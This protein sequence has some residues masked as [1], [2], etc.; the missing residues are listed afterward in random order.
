[1]RE[2][3]YTI[4][5]MKDVLLDMFKF[6]KQFLA[7]HNLH[8]VACGG[9]VLGAVRHKGF[10]PWDDDID[11]YMPRADY[12]RLLTMDDELRPLGY[13]ILSHEKT[14]GYYT[15]FAKLSKMQSTIWELEHLPCIMGVYID[16]FPLDEFDDSDEAITALQYKTHYYYDKYINAVSSY[17]PSY[18][19]QRLAQFDFHKAGV[20]LLHL[21][22]RRH[23]E[24]YL[25]AFLD[26]E[27]TYVGGH[28]PKCVCA[29]Q[30]EGRVFQTEWF[31][32]TV[33]LPFEDTTVAVPSD[34][35]AYLRLLYGDYMT[36][37]PEEKRFTHRHFFVDLTRRLTIEDILA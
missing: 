3:N 12:N 9:T 30:W 4:E 20:Y 37:P 8:Y 28:G 33:E 35:D 34:Y 27:R 22:R 19:F 25:K 2:S 15:P 24:R 11:I 6:L 31:K 23:P 1:M 16:L 7:D 21:Y 14:K 26:F 18:F 5:Q 29:T 32:D 36:L 17:P 13:E 10:I